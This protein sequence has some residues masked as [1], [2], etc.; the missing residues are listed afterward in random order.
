MAEKWKGDRGGA[1]RRRSELV[2]V[3]GIGSQLYGKMEDGGW[4]DAEME[5]MQRCRDAAPR[6]SAGCGISRR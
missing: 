4:T 6:G 5:E 1:E 2:E 3:P